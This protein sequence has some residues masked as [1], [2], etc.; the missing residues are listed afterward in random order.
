MNTHHPK[1]NFA[2][3]KSFLIAKKSKP[4]IDIAQKVKKECPKSNKTPKTTRFRKN[5]QNLQIEL[6]GWENIW[7]NRS[8]K[9]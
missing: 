4:R 3:K 1:I 5:R 6:V 7:L 8:G 9:N 2:L